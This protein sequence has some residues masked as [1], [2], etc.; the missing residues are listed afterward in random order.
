MAV[1]EE[2]LRVFQSVKIKIGKTGG[3]IPTPSVRAPLNGWLCVNGPDCRQCRQ[4]AEAGQIRPVPVVV[5][6]ITRLPPHHSSKVGE[7]R[8]SESRFL[9]LWEI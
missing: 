2:G 9:A 7:R 6:Q 1:E 5:I 4:E 8:G 3:K